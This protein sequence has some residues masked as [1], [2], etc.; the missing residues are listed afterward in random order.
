[1]D[2]Q[3]V[4]EYMMEQGLLNAVLD[5]CED[6]EQREATK[7]YAQ[8][9]CA[10]MDPFINSLREQCKNDEEREALLKSIVTAGGQKNAN[11]T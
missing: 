8:S 11:A 2:M 4:Y 6:D 9:V 10:K 1:M 7:K 5:A 3:T